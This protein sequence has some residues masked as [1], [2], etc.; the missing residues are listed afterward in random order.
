[1]IILDY[2][3]R[4]FKEI[5]DNNETRYFIRIKKEYIEIPVEVLK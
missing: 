4:D 3:R 2:K 5:K 1:M